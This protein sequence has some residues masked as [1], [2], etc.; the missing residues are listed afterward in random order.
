[1]LYYKCP[2]LN[3]NSNGLVPNSELKKQ[4]VMTEVT[5]PLPKQEELLAPTEIKNNL[6]I[7]FQKVWFKSYNNEYLY[8]TTM[9]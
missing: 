1:M 7:V 8:S 9:S 6:L 2:F 3:G 4:Q 5:E